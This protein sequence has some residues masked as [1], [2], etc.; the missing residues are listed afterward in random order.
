MCTATAA[1]LLRYSTCYSA[2][3]RWQPLTPVLQAVPRLK[4][5]WPAPK[6]DWDIVV[7]CGNKYY[8]IHSST[9]LRIGVYKY[10]Y[11]YKFYASIENLGGD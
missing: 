11:I 10:I 4:G 9:V 7:P 2:A 3:E 8:C 1:L 5:E 6:T